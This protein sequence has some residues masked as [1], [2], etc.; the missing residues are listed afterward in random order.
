MPQRY[1][2]PTVRGWIVPTI[3]GPLVS[4]YTTVLF[5]AIFWG[6]V[7]NIWRGVGWV[8]GM[9]F[10]TIWAVSYML[11]LGLVDVALLIVKLR[12]LPVGRR[13]WLMALA[14]PA[15]IAGVYKVVPPYKFYTSG[16]WGVILAFL[17]PMVVVTLIA[18]I[19][20]GSK[21]PR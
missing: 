9:L 12:T 10:G 15:V 1:V 11:L 5:A 19:A 3:V 16:P 20:F 8:A 7:G 14:C 2:R 13:A 18:R 17:I 6:D 4:V 21:P